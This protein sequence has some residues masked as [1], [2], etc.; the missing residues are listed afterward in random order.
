MQDS[1]NYKKWKT[2]KKIFVLHVTFSYDL[3]VMTTKKIII[4]QPKFDWY[5]VQGKR[6]DLVRR[7]LASHLKHTWFVESDKRPLDR[8]DF[9]TL[10]H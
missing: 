9:L 8:T 4:E 6:N 3:E 7:W 10:Y 5:Y 2:Y 1:L